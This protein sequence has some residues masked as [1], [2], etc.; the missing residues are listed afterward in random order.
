M[1]LWRWTR[2]A[3]DRLVGLGAFDGARVELIGGQVV[4]AAPE[5]AC[6]A[7]TIRA[8]DHALRAVLP[9]ELLLRVQQPVSLDDDSKPEPDLCVTP[10][11]RADGGRARPGR[12]VL[13]VEVAESSLAFDRVAKGSLY[14]R[15]DV[16]DYWI[17]NLVDR[18]IEVHR[19]PAPDSSAPYGWRYWS[20]T[21]LATG[22]VAPLALPDTP[23][24]AAALLP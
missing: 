15:A 23:I 4:V 13:V 7:V 22:A 9:P 17:V 10:E 3:Y 18:V 12:P 16:R 19:D 20:V 6:H 14:A 24:A 11:R 8:A 21:P 1:T 2:T 5:S